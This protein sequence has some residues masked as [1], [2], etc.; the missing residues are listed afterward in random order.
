MNLSKNELLA[1]ARGERE[2][3]ERTLRQFVEEVHQKKWYEQPLSLSAQ[4]SE[5]GTQQS[6]C[7]PALGG[8]ATGH[9][10]AHVVWRCACEHFV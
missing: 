3:F 8:H 10:E 4:R 6:A 1:F 2:R 7:R 5:L 9:Q